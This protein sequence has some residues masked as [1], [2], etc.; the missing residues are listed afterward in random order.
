MILRGVNG[1]ARALG[2]A[3]AAP[4][5]GARLK[6]RRRGCGTLLVLLPAAAMVSPVAAQEAIAVPSHQPVTLAQV[7]LDENPGELWVRFRFLTPQIAR[8]GG[9]IGADA[10]SADMDA[11]CDTVALPWLAGQKITPARIAISLMD[12]DVPFGAAD[13]DTTQFFASYRS[14]DGRCIWEEF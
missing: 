14:E 3:P 12:R 6:A 9:T 8:S 5:G 7:L 11:L 2:D 10:A 4:A 13:P 1:I